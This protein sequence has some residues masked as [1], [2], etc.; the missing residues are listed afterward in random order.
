MSSTMIIIIIV[1]VA[2]IALL[3]MAGDRKPRVTQIERTVERE[4]DQGK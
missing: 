4:E 1:V 2:V 3:L